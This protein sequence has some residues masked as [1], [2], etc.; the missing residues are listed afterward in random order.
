V[1]F[2]NPAA[3]SFKSQNTVNNISISVEAGKGLHANYRV[4]GYYGLG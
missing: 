2:L 4:E 3:L 1:Y